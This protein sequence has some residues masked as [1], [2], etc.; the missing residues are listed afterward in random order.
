MVVS[1]YQMCILMMFNQKSE[2]TVE[3]IREAMS[4]DEETV[5]KN[6]QSLMMSRYQILQK[7]DNVVRVND[8]YSSQL[9]KVT[10]PVPITEEVYKKEKVLEDRTHAIEANIVRVMK[11]RQKCDF[12]SL[13]Q[14]VM[15]TLQMFKPHPSTIKQKIEHLI[16]REYLVRSD[17]D[18]QVLKYLA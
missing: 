15:A 10:L 2:Y 17:E 5:K 12:N 3:E 7:T 8:N 9:N 1:T 18:P 6:L 16:H 11:A 14:E 4:F 13:M